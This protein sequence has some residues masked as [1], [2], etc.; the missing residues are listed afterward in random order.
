MSPPPHPFD[1]WY[2]RSRPKLLRLAV[3]RLRDR[4]E[5]EDVV[6]ETALAVWRRHEAGGVEDLDA[7]AA[8]SVWQNA[9]KRS[10]RLRRFESLEDAEADGLGVPDA[11][12][13][14]IDSLEMEEALAGLPLAQQTVLRMRFY[15]GLSFKE[16][17][18]ALSISLNTAASRCRYALE[19]LRK[20]FEN[21]NPKED[22]DAHQKRGKKPGAQAGA[23]RPARPARAELRRKQ[24]RGR[25]GDA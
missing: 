13:A 5:A 4:D 24:R 8:R 20:G 25:G 15:T 3:S 6:Q 9:I 17:A 11:V 16:T 1:A 22:H 23:A 10:T 19:S 2:E 21:P 14:W 7:Y 12:D 18:Q